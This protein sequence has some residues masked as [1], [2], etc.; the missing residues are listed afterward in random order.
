VDAIGGIRIDVPRDIPIGGGTTPAGN[1]NP[2][3]GYIDKGD[4]QLL[5]G[6]QALWFA[7]SR[8][9]STDYDRMRRQR[10]VIGA[11]I[12]QSDP[13]T[14]MRA[15][16]ELARTAQDNISTDIP[17]QDLQAWVELS[18][19]VKD[20]SVR[21]L[22]FTD[23]VIADRANPD[24]YQIQELVQEALTAPAPSPTPSAIPSPGTS[25]GGVTV[26]PSPAPV[27]EEVAQDVTAVC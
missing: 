13:V 10:C 17:Q 11:I 8:D 3:T 18:L 14:L 21:S 9:G 26:T 15:Y 23:E 12:Q 25:P 16:P 1:R 24:Y 2:I 4:N 22:P 6:Y 5:D 20:G 7:R 27:D 19:R